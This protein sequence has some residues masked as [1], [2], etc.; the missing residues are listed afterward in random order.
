[1]RDYADAVAVE[2][3]KQIKATTRNFSILLIL[4]APVDKRGRVST[5]RAIKINL[6]QQQ[7]PPASFLLANVLRTA[8]LP[9]KM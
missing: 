5:A 8:T 9:G 1:M 7:S 2:I 4:E 6:S 3:I